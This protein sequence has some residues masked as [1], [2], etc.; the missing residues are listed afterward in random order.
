MLR[1]YCGHQ[2]TPKRKAQQILA[3]TIANTHATWRDGYPDITERQARLIEE[4]LAKLSTRIAKILGC[5]DLTT[6]AI[7]A[8]AVE[9]D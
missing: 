2:T 4:Q 7:D 9:T 8:C 3:D 1:D 6:C 5:K